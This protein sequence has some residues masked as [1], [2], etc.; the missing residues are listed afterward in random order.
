MTDKK[1][2][3]CREDDWVQ[4]K[5]ECIDGKRKIW[6]QRKAISVITEENNSTFFCTRG[7]QKQDSEEECSKS[8]CMII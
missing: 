4:V 3:L 2:P 5:G 1:C 6:W 7:I 8:F